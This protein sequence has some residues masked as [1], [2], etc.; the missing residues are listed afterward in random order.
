MADAKFRS[1][2]AGRN[3]ESTRIAPRAR[4]SNGG[5]SRRSRRRF[6]GVLIEAVAL[7]DFHDATFH[8]KP[9]GLAIAFAEISPRVGNAPVSGSS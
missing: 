7:S 1:D 6:G 9:P 3:F 5:A 2:R 4:C 8:G